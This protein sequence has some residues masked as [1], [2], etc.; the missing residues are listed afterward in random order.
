MAIDLRD[1]AWIEN[2]PGKP[3]E[4][5]THHFISAGVGASGQPFYIASRRT[6]LSNMWFST[7]SLGATSIEYY[8][9]YY[10]RFDSTDKFYVMALRHTPEDLLAVHPPVP[11]D[12]SHATGPFYW[13]KVSEGSS[14][15]DVE[16]SFCKFVEVE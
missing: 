10:K 15:Y 8:D 12:A 3:L 2:E 11:N 1:I 9:V 7:V 5:G 4:E 14:Y 16:C 13:S 6:S